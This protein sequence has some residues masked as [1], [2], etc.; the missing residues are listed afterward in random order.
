MLDI[1]DEEDWVGTVLL[2]HL[3]DLNIVRLEVLT[4]RV[5]TK[6]LLAGIHLQNITHVSG[7]GGGLNGR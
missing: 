7:G 6:E 3:V 1:D 2:E 4:S 5:P